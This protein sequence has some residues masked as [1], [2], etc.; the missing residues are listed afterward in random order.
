MLIQEKALTYYPALMEVW[1]F[2]E[3]VL[4]PKGEYEV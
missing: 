1:D 3:V 2:K 4:F